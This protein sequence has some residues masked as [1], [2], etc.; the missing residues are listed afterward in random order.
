[1]TKLHP[2]LDPKS[3]ANTP[4]SVIEDALQAVRRHLDMPI[5]FLSLFDGDT[6]L[7]HTV[8]SDQLTPVIASGTRWPQDA[9]FCTAVRD[10]RLPQVIADT[11]AYPAAMALPMTSLAPIGAMI[12][13]PLRQGDNSVCGMFCCISPVP[14]PD[15]GD[16]AQAVMTTFASLVG[17][18]VAADQ[19]VAPGD[20]R[21]QQIADVI[22]DRDF[23]MLLQP[24]VALDTN[25]V[26][27]AEAL[28]RFRPTPYRSPDKWFAHARGVGLQRELECA[29]IEK[30]VDL[31]RDLPQALRLAINVSPDTLANTDLA[32]LID[33]PFSDRVIFE[34]TEHALVAEPAELQRRMKLL[35][36]VGARIAVDDLGASYGSL[37]T[38]LQI[39][40]DIVKLDRDLVRGINL[41]PVNRAL[42]VGVVTFAAA[43]GADV[44]AEGIERQGEA[45]TLR[46]IGVAFGQG[47]LLGRPGG[48]N[49]LQ[50]RTYTY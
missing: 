7:V 47:F 2:L 13:I 10:G 26:M 38:V 9:T 24:I 46:E 31:L 12:A 44:I 5:A 17:D 33:G 6:V 1:M 15:L 48:M 21:R 14:R 4:R 40:P 35:R 49:A 37:S 22:A 25:A 20:L 42:A 45:D 41:D 39:K 36:R 34:L 28:C 32:A 3:P 50:A 43:I 30:A 16:R 29:V 18:S 11:H 23:Q 19:V 27:G 8:S